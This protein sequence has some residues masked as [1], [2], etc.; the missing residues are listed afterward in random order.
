MPNP[1][2]SVAPTS[3]PIHFDEMRDHA[4]I[5]STGEQTLIELYIAAAREYVEEAVLGRTLF[6]TTW[7][8]ILDDF[9]S[10]GADFI[11]PMPPLQS[12]SSI[13]YTDTDGTTQTWA[14][15][16]YDVDIANEPARISLA[17]GEV[18]PS[19][20]QINNSVT[21][22]YV[23]GSSSTGDIP[24]NYRLGI[25]QLATLW[26]EHRTP[27]DKASEMAMVPESMMA[28]FGATPAKIH[29]V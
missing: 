2:R 18:Y 1:K 11:V 26:Y 13:G 5:D 12:V 7:E 16:S 6:T 21:V 28:L 15:T 10:G 17:Y 9:P 27:V 29:Y 23:A 8:W 4:R 19:T 20:R 22:T 25:A 3:E 24:N 14:S